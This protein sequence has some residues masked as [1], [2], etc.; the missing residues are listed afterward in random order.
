VL[1]S[2]QERTARL[3]P[4]DERDQ[5][6]EAP[7]DPIPFGADF[8]QLCDRS[9]YP[10]PLQGQGLTSAVSDSDAAMGADLQTTA[11]RVSKPPFRLPCNMA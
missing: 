5:I 2:R 9:Q 7:A 10:G 3:A 1:E 8:F 4:V 11:S 6:E